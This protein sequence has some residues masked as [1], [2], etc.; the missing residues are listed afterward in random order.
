MSYEV[1][2]AIVPRSKG[3]EFREGGRTHHN[4]RAESRQVVFEA[5]PGTILV[6]LRSRPASDDSG[7]HHGRPEACCPAGRGAIPSP[8]EA[9]YAGG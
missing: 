6:C 8:D 3:R 4:V 9:G 5:R 2:T 1:K 7:L